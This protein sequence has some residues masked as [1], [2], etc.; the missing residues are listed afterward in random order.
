MHRRGEGVCDRWRIMCCTRSS[1]VHY[2]I[3]THLA[4]KS[5][6]SGRINGTTARSSRGAGLDLRPPGLW[7]AWSWSEPPDPSTMRPFWY[8]VVQTDLHAVIRANILEEVH[9][10]YIMYQLFKSLKYM[11]SGELLHR[12]IKVR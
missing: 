12:D 7:Q 9:K 10:Q 6:F 1:A 3:R 2:A 5:R 4:L 11:H 8:C